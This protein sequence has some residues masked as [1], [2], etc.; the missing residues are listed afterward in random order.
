[1]FLGIQASTVNYTQFSRYFSLPMTRTA[2]VCL[3]TACLMFGVHEFL[4]I[5]DFLAIPDVIAFPVDQQL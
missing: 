4:S 3:M 2:A 5:V 1:M